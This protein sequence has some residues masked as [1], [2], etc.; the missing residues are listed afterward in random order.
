MPNLW[1]LTFYKLTFNAFF[2]CQWPVLNAIIKCAAF[3][4]YCTDC[5]I[6]KS[7]FAPLILDLLLALRSG[8]GGT[9]LIECG[10]RVNISK[11]HVSLMFLERPLLLLIMIKCPIV[12]AEKLL[13]FTADEFISG[14]KKC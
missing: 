14:K 10:R 4:I 8:C 12:N 3:L 7:P 5:T 1:P 2:P 13:Y 9:L 11:V 6:V